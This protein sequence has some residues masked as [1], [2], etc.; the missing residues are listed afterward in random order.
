LLPSEETQLTADLV[1]VRGET[2]R[3]TFHDNG[4]CQPAEIQKCTQQRTIA[5]SYTGSDGD[6]EL[7]KAYSPNLDWL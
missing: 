3:L 4:F 2:Y 1:T 5:L 7:L 6:L